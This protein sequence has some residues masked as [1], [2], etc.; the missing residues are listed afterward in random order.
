MRAVFIGVNN[1]YFNPVHGALRTALIDAFN[2]DVYGL[3]YSSAKPDFSEYDVLLSDGSLLIDDTKGAFKNS[4]LE[5][6]E[7]SDV[8]FEIQDIWSTFQGIRILYTNI[9]FH[10]VKESLIQ[11]LNRYENT[12]FVTWGKEL[13][14]SLDDLSDL[15]VEPFVKLANDNWYIWA[16]EN[17]EKILSIPQIYLDEISVR[18]QRFLPLQV[19][20]ANY[21]YRRI[22][23]KYLGSKSCYFRFADFLFLNLFRICLRL[24]SSWSFSLMKHILMF[25]CNRSNGVVV[26]GS[27]LEYPVAKYFEIPAYGGMIISAPNRFLEN[28]GLR[29]DIHY[30]EIK[31]NEMNLLDS[32]SLNLSIVQNARNV[33][34]RNH[35]YTARVQQFVEFRSRIMDKKFAGASW[36]DGVLIFH[37][38]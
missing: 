4:I 14:L 28:I 3:G 27:S 15:E 20:G 9:D 29:K 2:A 8:L 30:I 21:T 16:S 32:I 6:G 19:I 33:L 25:R 5:G 12:Y 17:Q 38:K 37:E 35:S 24:K 13:L 34:N 18:T 1:K 7:Y 26:C 23:R 22:A 36:E 11:E 10:N 31:R